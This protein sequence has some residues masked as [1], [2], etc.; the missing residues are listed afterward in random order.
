MTTIINN[1]NVNCP[2]VGFTTATTVDDVANNKNN[3]VIEKIMEILRKYKTG[4]NSDVAHTTE[5]I[6]TTVHS[7]SKVRLRPKANFVQDATKTERTLYANYPYVFPPHK[8]IPARTKLENLK[9]QQPPIPKR[10]LPPL[11]NTY[12]GKDFK[13]RPITFQT[14]L[15][16]IPP[17]GVPVSDLVLPLSHNIIISTSPPYVQQLQMFPNRQDRLFK[18]HLTSN[19]LKTVQKNNILKHPNIDNNERGSNKKKLTD[20]RTRN[21]DSDDNTDDEGLKKN[22][23]KENKK[24]FE[25]RTGNNDSGDN[26]KDGGLRYSTYKKNTARNKNGPRYHEKLENYQQSNADLEATSDGDCCK[27]EIFTREQRPIKHTKKDNVSFKKLLKTQQRV[28]EMLERMLA[29]SKAE[30]PISVET[31]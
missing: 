13:S 20:Y 27:D 8:K 28:T 12:I 17:L 22:K 6:D 29:K 4:N 15:I 25:Y 11:I 1:G 31:T 24:Q 7:T 2:I 16:E 10:H 21:N 18:S 9:R 5:T 14:N 19:K 26:T 3:I 30:Q 23:Y